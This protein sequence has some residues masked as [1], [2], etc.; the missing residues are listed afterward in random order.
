MASKYVPP[1]RDVG[2]ELVQYL[3]RHPGEIRERVMGTESELGPQVRVLHGESTVVFA[4]LRRPARPQPHLAL[5]RRGQRVVDVLVVT[6]VDGPVREG[7]RDGRCGIA[8]RLFEVAGVELQEI[9]HLLGATDL[10]G[11]LVPNRPAA[12]AR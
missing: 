1:G 2:T 4:V 5:Q 8:V 7:D 11:R 6:A 9:G 3:V 12:I 10:P